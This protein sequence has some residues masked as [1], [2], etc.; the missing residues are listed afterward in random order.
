[1]FF[2]ITIGIGL[3]LLF[4]SSTLWKSYCI[5]AYTELNKQRSKVQK[6]RMQDYQREE[7][8]ELEWFSAQLLGRE[9]FYENRIHGLLRA[10]SYIT[11][12][13]LSISLQ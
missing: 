5:H 9:A 13:S 11:L 3:L 8:S 10:Y 7:V 1:M 6:K 2:F 12:L 4:F